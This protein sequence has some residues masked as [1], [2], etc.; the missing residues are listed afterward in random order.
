MNILDVISIEQLEQDPGNTLLKKLKS[1]KKEEFLP[2]D[3]I[4]FSCY[5]DIDTNTLYHIEWCCYYIDI[6]FFFVTCNTD[7]PA[8]KNFFKNLDDSIEIINEKS[9]HPLLRET[10]HTPVFYNQNLCTHP[11]T[12][13]HIWPDGGASIC[14]EAGSRLGEYNVKNDSL[15]DIFNSKEMAEIRNTFRQ[16]KTPDQCMSCV[17][18]EQQGQQSKRRL[19]QHKHK[20]IIHKV[21][22]ESEGELFFIGGHL[23][24]VCNAKCRICSSFYSSSI[25]AEDIKFGTA[26]EKQQA[27]NYLKENVWK[28]F[29]FW[30]LLKGHDSLCNFEFLGGETFLQQRNLEYLQW[31]VDTNKSEHCMFEIV[32]NGSTIPDSIKNYSDKFENLSITVSIDNIHER[33]ELERSGVKWADLDKNLDVFCGLPK[34][35]V[36]VNVTVSV[37]N[38]YYLPEI[39][40]WLKTKRISYYHVSILTYPDHLSINKL[41]HEYKNA[42]I[43]KLE[44][45]NCNDID[46]VLNAVRKSKDTDGADFTQ[47]MKF[48]D[49][50]RQENFANTHPEVSMYYYKDV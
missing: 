49:G 21:A 10:G 38:V 32:T 22:F 9:L 37:M 33:F 16:G 18:K 23:G 34:C 44:K 39:I 12:G 24:N 35:S 42:I 3:R 45:Y 13:V 48:K 36:G 26:D 5:S 15:D 2:D 19:V 47:Y 8:V 31:L 50:I 4:V 27:V 14:C 1:L 20:N 7:R 41:P 40:E 46:H 17:N 6:P 43:E 28:N 11:W 25:A 30:E 29:N